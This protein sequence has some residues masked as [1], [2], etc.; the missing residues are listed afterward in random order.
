MNPHYRNFKK[1]ILLGSDSD[2]IEVPGLQIDVIEKVIE[3]DC[4]FPNFDSVNRS[5]E[6]QEPLA[7]ESR[8]LAISKEVFDCSGRALPYSLRQ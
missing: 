7:W 3:C 5:T 4:V 2:L 6:A 1:G 8:Y